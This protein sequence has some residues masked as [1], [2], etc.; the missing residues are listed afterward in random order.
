MQFT[1]IFTD[2][3]AEARSKLF[4]ATHRSDLSSAEDT[5]NLKRKII[6]ESL[7]P[8]DSSNKKIVKHGSVSNTCPPRYNDYLKGNLVFSL[9]IL[10]NML[11]NFCT[12]PTIFSLWSFFHA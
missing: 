11:D 7:S 12:V 8:D 6:C 4:T 5:M 2:S 10:F 9:V 1:Y 3:L